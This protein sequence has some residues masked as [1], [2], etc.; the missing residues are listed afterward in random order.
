VLDLHAPYVSLARRT[1][2]RYLG[3][4]LPDFMAHCYV[5]GCDVKK[6]DHRALVGQ[7]REAY[8]ESVTDIEAHVAE[9][10]RIAEQRKRPFRLVVTSDHGE[11]FGEHGAFAHGGGFVPELL[12]VPF[13]VYD[14]TARR[15]SRTCD[16]LTTAEALRVVTEAD[17]AS[18]RVSHDR[19]EID[20][21]PLGRA[22]VDAPNG[23]I[24]YTIAEGYVRHRNT[25]RNL[26]PDATGV[27]PWTPAR[28]AQRA[29]SPAGPVGP[30]ARPPSRSLP[31]P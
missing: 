28:C 8:L 15:G 30:F 19:I 11:L 6:E 3:S 14:S 22:V 2:D 21:H 9:V 7:A 27:V 5:G 26:H 24:T 20:G 18:P 12:S 23:T 10:F 13:V 25:W 4:T 1:D 17:P 31:P 29:F 16:L